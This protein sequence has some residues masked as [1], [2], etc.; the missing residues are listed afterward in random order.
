MTG[1]PSVS[2]QNKVRP[3]AL[4]QDATSQQF[5]NT[6]YRLPQLPVHIRHTTYNVMH[7]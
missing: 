4:G 6:K 3:L 7:V 1:I 5:R 2:G